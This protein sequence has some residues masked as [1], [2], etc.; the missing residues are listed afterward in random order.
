MTS[1]YKA[2]L[3]EFLNSYIDVEPKGLEDGIMIEK[4]IR[5]GLKLLVNEGF[6]TRDEL[7]K[8]LLSRYGILV[9]I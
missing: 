7:R 9:I 1:D 4:A 8:L 5:Q 6:Y 2:K 3:T